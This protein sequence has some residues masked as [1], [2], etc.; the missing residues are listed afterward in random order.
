MIGVTYI[1]EDARVVT[2]ISIFVDRDSRACILGSK[3]ALRLVRGIEVW[4]C[5]HDAHLILYHVTSGRGVTGIDRFF[6]KAG[7]TT[8]GGSYGV[9]LC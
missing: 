2:V 6:R 9:R 1:G 7:M 5:M 8:L 4:G 3:V